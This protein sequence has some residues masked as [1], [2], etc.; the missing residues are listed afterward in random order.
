MYITLS[1]HLDEMSLVSNDYMCT[2]VSTQIDT[3]P[4]S[5]QDAMFHQVSKLECSHFQ[6]VTIPIWDA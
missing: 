4:V 2:C 3:N 6:I 1:K 5:K